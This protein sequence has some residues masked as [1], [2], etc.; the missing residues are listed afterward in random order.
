MTINWPDIHGT[1]KVPYS[2]YTDE[3]QYQLELDKIW[4]GNHYSY[5]GLECEVPNIGDYKL[6][7][8]GERQVIVVR[9]EKGISVL[10]NRCKHRGV[11]FEV[12]QRGNKLKFTCPYHQWKYN[13]EGDLVI[14]PFEKGAK[15]N[16][17]VRGG[18][19]ENF[20]KK[21]HHLTRCTVAVLHGVIFA[22]FGDNLPSIEDYITPTILPWFE[23]TF[24]NRKLKLLG[25]TRQEIGGNWK[26]MMENIK[27]PYHP[28]L[29]HTWFVT[30][31]LFRADHSISRMV[32]DESGKHAVML[33]RRGNALVENEV[34]KDADSFRSKMKLNDN[35]L[36]D[37]VEEDWWSISD[38]DNPNDTITPT[39]CM[40][41]L[42]PSVIIQQQINSL[43]T[44]QI[45]P[46]GKGVFEFTWTHFGF[47]DDTEEMTVRRLRQANLFGPAGFVSA[48]DGI[49]L[50][51]QQ[52]GFNQSQAG[53]Y[54]LAELDGPDNGVVTEHMN[55]E[56]LI[57]G[58]YRYY[59][60]A[61]G[62]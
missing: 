37:I 45:V 36:L 6:S 13:L 7:Y 60:E 17:I 58:M 32:I 27:D 34:T 48:D 5:V 24:K 40:Q 22:S 31:G 38:P 2:V 51:L 53:E 21:D 14:V 3:A 57:R 46:K 41:T 47:E 59:K 20:N 10:E 50:E 56:T 16:G 33:N 29:L 11:Q 25:Y 4:Y 26:L 42:F 55:T 12:N 15:K 8:I 49:A 39:N 1:N 18:M 19:P 43:G 23:R 61:M 28:G 52:D 44:R 35:R 54:L 30:F 62:L 9:N